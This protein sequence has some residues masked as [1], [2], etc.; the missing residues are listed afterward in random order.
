MALWQRNSD[1][2]M[3]FVFFMSLLTDW[4]LSPIGNTIVTAHTYLNIYVVFCTLQ[5]VF[6]LESTIVYWRF[7]Y[8]FPT[9]S[10]PWKDTYLKLKKT[11]I[12]LSYISNTKS[13]S[14][15]SFRNVMKSEFHLNLSTC[16]L[17]ICSKDAYPWK[18][19]VVKYILFFC[20]KFF[21]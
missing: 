18:Q 2:V 1:A 11:F 21:F 17:L 4:D 20:I 13:I 10:L 15:S 5:L 3:K 16:E 8:L 12:Y 7:I 6:W 14:S 9:L 19:V